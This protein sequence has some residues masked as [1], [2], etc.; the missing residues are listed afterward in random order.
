MRVKQRRAWLRLVLNSVLGFI[1]LA[2]VFY[3]GVS[4]GNGTISLNRNSENKNLPSKLNYSQVDQ[5]YRSLKGAYDG[6]LTESQ[7]ID[8]LKHGLAEATKDPYTVYFSPSE[9]RKFDEQLNNSFAGIGARLSKNSDGYL[10]IGEAIKG[11]PAAKAGLK[12]QDI[13]VTINGDDASKLTLDEA[14]AKIR[15]PAG[16]R[17]KLQVIRDRAQTLNFTITRAEIKLPSVNTKLLPG[18]IGY[19]Q[20]TSFSNDTIDLADKAAN[21]FAA[22]HVKGIILDLRDDPGGYLDAAKAVSS[23]W[24]PQG[25]MIL[26]ERRDTTITDTAYATGGDVLN[27]IKTV[28]LINGGSASA[29]EITAG[30]LHDNGVAYLIGEKSYGKGVVQDQINFGDGSRLKVTIASW[31]RPNGQNINKKGVQPDKTVKISL[32]DIKAGNDTQ[33]KAAEAYLLHK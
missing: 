5:V 2:G 4:V 19:L 22:K 23:L 13:I 12:A 18:N 6:K 20:I 26:Q 29:S 16:S 10:V 3:A 7:L 33:L 8:G 24:L 27:G 17:V 32:A 30:A 14:I 25:K 11:F 28:V 21:E 9:A 1:V 31:F 15:G